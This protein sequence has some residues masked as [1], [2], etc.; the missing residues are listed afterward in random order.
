[1][2][3]VAVPIAIRIAKLNAI[4]IVIAMYFAISIWS[5][6]HEDIDHID[7][8]VVAT[9]GSFVPVSICASGRPRS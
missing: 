4:G 1:M 9:Q 3:K 2:R 8:F 7:S 6:K 5:L